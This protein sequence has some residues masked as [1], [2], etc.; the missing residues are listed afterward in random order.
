MISIGWILF[1]IFGW[2]V[3][4]KGRCSPFSPTYV[5]AYFISLSTSIATQQMISNKTISVLAHC[6]MGDKKPCVYP[7][8]IWNRWIVENRFFLSSYNEMISFWPREFLKFVND[9]MPH[10]ATTHVFLL[11]PPDWTSP[12]VY[13]VWRAPSATSLTTRTSSMWLLN[14]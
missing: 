10:W 13:Q 4:P 11:P 2:A 1:P 7:L 3:F 5:H 9:N 14:E 12:P 8:E 6:P